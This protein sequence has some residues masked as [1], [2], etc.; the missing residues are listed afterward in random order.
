MADNK[1]KSRLESD[2][3]DLPPE[4]SGDAIDRILTKPEQEHLAE[5][6]AADAIDALPLIGDLLTVARMKEAE[7]KGIEYPD[8]PT[9]VENALSD[10]PAPLDTVGDIIISQN[11][12]T[13]LEVED[14]VKGRRTPSAFIEDASVSL[15]DWVGRITPGGDN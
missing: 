11:T 10:I 8:R 1:L 4:L 5:A 13:Y 3:G 12:L 14:E 2:L 15:A 9:A 6:L 7:E